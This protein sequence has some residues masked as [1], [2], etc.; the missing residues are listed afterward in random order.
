[1]AHTHKNRS[2]VAFFPEVT[3][4]VPPAN[5]A[6][7]VSSGTAILHTGADFSAV[8]DARLDDPTMETRAMAQGTR[9]KIPGA[10][11]V[12]ASVSVS[13]TGSG[14]ETADGAAITETALMTIMEHCMGGLDLGT[15]QTVDAT[16]GS[17][18]QPQ[19]DSVTG[20]T[21]GCLV[22][23]EDTTSPTAENTGK[24][25]FRRV[26]SIAT[27]V[28]TLSEA[29]PFTP[30]EGDLC[31]AVA[32]C[33]ID[34]DV[35]ED[36]VA[37]PSTFSWLGMK[38]SSRT[39]TIVQ[40]EG[41]V[42]SLGLS[43]LGKNEL[44]QV[45]LKIQAANYLLGGTDS[46]TNPAFATFNGQ[47]PLSMGVDVL[48]SIQAYGTTTV[49]LRDVNQI[50]FDPGFTRS[51]VPTTT[52]KTA[53]FEGLATYSVNISKTRL[54]LTLAPY[55]DDFYAG[56]EAGTTYRI[57]IYQPGTGTG[58]GQAWCLHLARAQ[59]VEVPSRVDVGDA[60][61]ITLVFEAMEAADGPTTDM[62]K[63]RFLI[64]I[65]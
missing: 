49:S 12:E 53:R 46:L 2:W 4:C 11:N 63:S 31:H 28:L 37:G 58:G 3:V 6:A 38:H 15:T 7:W 24:L 17:A 25:H 8:K 20:I 23:F 19:L 52:E 59:L 18:T 22:A 16:P 40:L 47:A 34:E 32:T 10:R 48:C 13:L 29:L 9:V 60:L 65:A 33:Y 43:G 42:A 44:P 41:C 54:T 39:D 64:G 57:N 26:Q 35:L 61:G 5:A 27:T 14:A 36:A 21:A 1:M 50:A 55:D 62:G 56:I 30:A 45:D 51:P